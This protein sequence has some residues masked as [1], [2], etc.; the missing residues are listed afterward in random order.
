M[1]KVPRLQDAKPYEAP[2]HFACTPVRFRV[3]DASPT[4]GFWVGLLHF[5]PAG[6]CKRD[7]KPLE[8]VYIVTQG[9]VAVVTDDGKA[10]L[11][12][13]NSFHLA[14]DE[15]R[16]VENRTDTPP[17]MMTVMLYPAGTTK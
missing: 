1:M 10:A 9:E 11:G 17:S 16:A 12:S 3:W 14:A 15:S 5:L 7:A 8:K 2:K 4:Q 6:G 13:D